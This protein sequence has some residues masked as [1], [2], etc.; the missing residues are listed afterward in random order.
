[1]VGRSH[2]PDRLGAPSPRPRRDGLPRHPGLLPHRGGDRPEHPGRRSSGLTRPTSTRRSLDPRRAAC[3]SCRTAGIS[4]EHPLGI[5]SGTG[6]DILAQ[7]VNGIRISLII[8][9]SATLLTVVIG[10]IVGIIAGLLRRVD[11]HARRAVH[12]PDARLPVP[13]VILALSNPLTQRLTELGR[14]G[15]QRVARPVPDPRRSA[16]S[17]GRTW[18]ASC[19]AR[20]SAFGSAS[21]WRPRSPWAPRGAGSCSARSCRTSGRRSWST[22]R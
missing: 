3:R 22:R 1:M 12:G 16:S 5:E 14:P 15:W 19:A 6:R 4:I 13:P 2:P 17:A 18:R 7:L 8:A 20:S 21:S 11:G 10:T 9:G